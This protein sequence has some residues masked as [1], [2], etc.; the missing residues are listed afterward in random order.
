MAVELLS[1]GS[2]WLAY[3]ELLLA[4][5]L[6]IL[7]NSTWDVDMMNA[8]VIS[9]AIFVVVT[10]LW[11]N[12]HQPRQKEED[13]SLQLETANYKQAEYA[14]QACTSLSLPC[15]FLLWNIDLWN[16]L[17]S[18]YE[19]STTPG[20]DKIVILHRPQFDSPDCL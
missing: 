6:P 17:S 16:K 15:A 8:F 10:Q 2:R 19:L 14:P 11:L 7:R 3:A 4:I 20:P 13:L 9:G 5:V 12:E 1:P 18:R